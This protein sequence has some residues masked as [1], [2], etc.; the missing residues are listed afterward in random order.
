MI[1]ISQI[2][3]DIVN[4][5]DF[6]K[7]GLAEG[8]V[9]FS[10]LARKIKPKIEEKLLFEVT[11]GSIIMALKRYSSFLKDKNIEINNP[12]KV[13]NITVRSNL[14]EYAFQISSRLNSIH[15]KLLAFAEKKEDPFVNFA[16][17]VFETTLI[18]SENLS[19]FFEE[20]SKDENLIAKFE[21]LS[22]ISIRLPIDTAI[23]AGVY[24]PFF[25][26]LALE[27]INF[28]EIISVFSEL[29]FVFKDQDVERAF[30]VLKSV[31]KRAG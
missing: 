25:R 27:G 6:L 15:K 7:E 24:Y 22:S 17:G 4:R 1:T 3:E 28:I 26:A 11:E 9:N 5:S 20:L 12:A 31:A 10:A 21:G 2:V 18:L 29:T 13:K 23:T 19:L 30:A 16:Q 8:I 14:V